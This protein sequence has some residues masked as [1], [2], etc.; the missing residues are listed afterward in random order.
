MGSLQV[1]L[2]KLGVHLSIELR[3]DGL[4]QLLV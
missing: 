2:Y 3:L 1:Q 4:G